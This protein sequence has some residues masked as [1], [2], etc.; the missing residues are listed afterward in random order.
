VDRQ[1]ASI[2]CKTLSCRAAMMT[3]EATL[4]HRHRDGVSQWAYR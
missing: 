1:R 4:V 3:S 2:F